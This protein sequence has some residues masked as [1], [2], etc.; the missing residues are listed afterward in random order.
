MSS[1]K[2]TE[3]T[4]LATSDNDDVVVIVDI[5]ASETKKQTKENLLKEVYTKDEVDALMTAIDIPEI[6][7][8]SQCDGATSAFALGQTVKVVIYV[9]LGGTLV[10]YTLNGAK[11]QISLTFNPDSGE[12]LFAIC[13]VY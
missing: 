13:L 4:E 12:E 2:I 7:L 6:D 5:S 3:L 10:N 8:S 11:N 1:K 9:K